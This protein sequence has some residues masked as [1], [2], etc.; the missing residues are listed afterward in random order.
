MT[1]RLDAIRARV[2]AATPGEWKETFTYRFDEEDNCSKGYMLDG[3]R[4][5]YTGMLYERAD[6]EFAAY[7]RADI[8]RLTAEVRAL[9]AQAAADKG[10][11]EAAMAQRVAGRRLRAGAGMSAVKALLAADVALD[12]A[13]AA[14]EGEE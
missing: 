11:V 8:P 5:A 3:P 10:V 14:L 4:P 9:G 12:A 2:E 1:S 7:A 6:A 13:L